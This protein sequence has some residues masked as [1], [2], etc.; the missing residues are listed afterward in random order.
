MGSAVGAVLGADQAQQ[1]SIA[2]STARDQGLQAFRGV[3][4]PSVHD[5]ELDLLQ[6]QYLG[7]LSPQQ[8]A[9]MGMGP[10][11]MQGI[12]VDPR[13]AQAQM[14]ALNQLS[15][16][17][18]MGMTPG[19]A[20]A[21]RDAQRQASAGA[22]AKSAQ[23]QDEF[24]RRGMGGSGNELAARLLAAQSGADRA[25]QSSNQIAQQAQ[26]A[27]LQA[28]GQ[29]AGLAGQMS[30]QSFGQQSDIAKAKDY[31]NQFNT[32]NQQAVQQR[33]IG[34]QNQ[35]AARNLDT[36][37]GIANQNTQL[38]NQQQQYNKQLQQQEFENRMAR[39]AGM[40]GQYGGIAK[41]RQEQAGRTAD[42]YAGIGKGVDT[43]VG[44]Y[45]NSQDKN[46][47]SDKTKKDWLDSGDI[48]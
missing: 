3:N 4:V 5:Q 44:S 20:A 6:N 32:Q 34:A 11:A 21:L 23:L 25:S 12:Q 45:M 26:Q 47:F 14:T 13:L 38:Q 37:Q 10:S 24:A 8:E 36:R 16:T 7:N 29:S 2:A 31:I 1:D 33:N 30:Q 35:A 18:Q 22:Q 40:A 41:S 17:G 39:A 15:Q 46:D 19:E 9:A 42:M 48:S 43:G 28:M 27:A